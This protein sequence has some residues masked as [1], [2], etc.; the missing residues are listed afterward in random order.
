MFLFVPSRAPPPKSEY[1][2]YRLDEATHSW[3]DTTVQIDT[4]DQTHGDYLWD[5]R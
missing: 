2:I 3:I 4:R 5:E 1:R